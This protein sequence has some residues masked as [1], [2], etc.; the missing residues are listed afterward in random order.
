MRC[1]G[2]L[3]GMGPEATVLLMR[4][5]ID[6][7]PARDDADHVP[8]LVDQNPQVPSR[9]ARLIE[10]RGEDPGPV[11]ADMA[12]RLEAAGATALAMPCNTAHHFAPAIRSASSVPFLD[13][14]AL[15]VRRAAEAAPP[16]GRIGILASPAV[17]RTALFEPALAAAGLSAVY[18]SDEDAL[19]A[20]IREIKSAGPTP[21]AIAAVRGASAELA[22]AGAPLQLVACTEFSLLD[23]P[24]AAGARL[25]DTLDLLVEVIVAHASGDQAAR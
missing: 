7:V 10:G 18:P 24:G 20:A 21:T 16:S 17:R 5:V 11:L 8:L 19:L 14:V 15:S 4:R 12:R 6:A 22:T 25:L 1:V 9:I 23:A 3:G 13:M 2:I